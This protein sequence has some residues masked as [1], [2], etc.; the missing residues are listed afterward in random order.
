MLSLTWGLWKSSFWFNYSHFW[1]KR[2]LE[3]S[4]LAGGGFCFDL[5]ASKPAQQERA[6][7][8]AVWWSCWEQRQHP[9]L[10]STPATQGNWGEPLSSFALSSSV[11][12]RELSLALFMRRLGGNINPATG[13]QQFEIL[14][15]LLRASFHLIS[16]R[17][18]SGSGYHLH[19]QEGS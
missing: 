17:A 5:C 9:R 19:F 13:L 8:P 6:F 16:T 7:D 2:Q 3:P 15:V 4:K 1:S 14:K 12:Q 10:D 18:F 11:R